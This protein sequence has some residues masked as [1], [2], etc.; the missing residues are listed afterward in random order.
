MRSPT[1]TGRILGCASAGHCEHHQVAH[2]LPF[3]GDVIASWLHVHEMLASDARA[4]PPPILDHL[5]HGG[6]GA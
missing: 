2:L 4:H 6:A 3:A 1:T 5:Q